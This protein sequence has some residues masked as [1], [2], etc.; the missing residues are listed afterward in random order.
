MYR[1][2]ENQ[3]FRTRYRPY[4]KNAN[5]SRRGGVSSAEDI[6]KSALRS[7]GLDKRIARYRFVLHW[8][9]IVG[10]SIAKNSKPECIRNNALVVRVA[11]S[12]WA[13]TLSFQKE[14]ILGRLK[15]FLNQDDIVD[16]V[17]FYVVG[18]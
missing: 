14:V 1:G 8:E 17:Q 13:Q 7:S 3:P 10:A 16:D 15:R 2:G 6:L 5:R 4:R 18:Q 9:E 12:C 11:D